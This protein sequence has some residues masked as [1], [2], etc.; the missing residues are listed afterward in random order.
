MDEAI[1]EFTQAAQ[2][3]QKELPPPLLTTPFVQEPPLGVVPI[4]PLVPV[5]PRVLTA[6]RE[7]N[8]C[9]PPNFSGDFDLMEAELWLKRIVRIFEHFRLVDDHLHVDA[10]NFQFF[11]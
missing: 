6:M 8:K 4:V 11:G 5:R 9:N 7:F 1:R 2:G 3:A 10:A